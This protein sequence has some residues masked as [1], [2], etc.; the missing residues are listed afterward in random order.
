MH[1]RATKAAGDRGIEKID[2]ERVID[3]APDAGWRDSPIAGSAIGIEPSDH[4]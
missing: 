2:G 3:D 4:Q 1:Q